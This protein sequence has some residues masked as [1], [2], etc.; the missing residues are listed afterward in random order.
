[1]KKIITSVLLLLCSWTLFGQTSK[2]FLRKRHLRR[3]E[4]SR[5]ERSAILSMDTIFTSGVPYAL[6]KD[7]QNT[8]VLYSLQGKELAYIQRECAGGN[9]LNYVQ[10]AC[11]YA[12]NF[13][14]S[15]KRGEI[16]YDLGL[17]VEGVIVADNLVQDS[18]INPS[19][20]A[21][22]L[23]RNPPKYSTNPPSSPIVIVLGDLGI[24]SSTQTN[25]TTEPVDIY[26]T[27]ERDRSDRITIYGNRIEQDFK[28]VGTVESP[29]FSLVFML[30]NGTKVAE[31]TEDRDSKS[32]EDVWKVVTL[33]DNRVHLVTTKYS[34]KEENIA[35]YL[36]DHYY[37]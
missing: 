33:K 17:N 4:Q 12:F 23:L 16:Q 6:L 22:F 28:V 26:Q 27:V 19:S 36:S 1:M 34:D 37:L 13:L 3:I 20:E 11:Y 8:Q 29:S 30:P 18:I 21:K 2:E 35:K 25:T 5:L 32:K 9:Y 24:S 7:K 15:G 10:G 14:E 31:A